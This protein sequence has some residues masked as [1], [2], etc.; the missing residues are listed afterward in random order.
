MSW[1]P[2]NER[3]DCRV[4]GVWRCM[5]CG[6]MRRPA[7]LLRLDLQFCAHCLSTH[8]IVVATQHGD[9]RIQREHDE[10]AERLLETA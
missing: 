8:G 7:N 4:C 2:Q 1:L 9:P 6:W 3:H 5:E 10:D